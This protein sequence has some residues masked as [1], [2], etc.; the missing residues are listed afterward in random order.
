MQT[1]QLGLL[2]GTEKIAAK[3]VLRWGAARASL[4]AITRWEF[5]FAAGRPVYRALWM[6]PTSS[7]TFQRIRYISIEMHIFFL[8]VRMYAAAVEW[9]VSKS[10]SMYGPRRRLPKKD[11]RFEGGGWGWLEAGEAICS[12]FNWQCMNRED[13]LEWALMCLKSVKPLFRWPHL[14]FLAW[15]VEWYLGAIP[16]LACYQYC[17]DCEIGVLRLH[18]R[19][20]SSC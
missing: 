7:L 12:H 11:Q 16:A 9:S 13:P 19:V 17:S 4:F 1:A 14:D 3:S 2:I 8:F 10:V 15:Y 6:L 20:I 5:S 18:V